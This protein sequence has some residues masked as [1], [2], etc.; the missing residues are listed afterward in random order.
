MVVLTHKIR[1]YPTGED[2][3][4]FKKYIIGLWVW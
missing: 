4:N 3:V 2:I 1:I